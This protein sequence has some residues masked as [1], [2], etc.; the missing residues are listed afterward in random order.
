MSEAQN[1]EIV[2]SAYAAFGRGD[3]AGVINLLAEDIEWVDPGPPAVPFA[4]TH[5]GRA[6]VM[7]MF[8]RLGE[9]VQFTKFEP[10]DFIAQGDR[11]ICLGFF[12]GTVKKTSHMFSSD[13]AMAFTLLAGKII[14]FREYNDTHAIAS[15]FKEYED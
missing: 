1:V 9:T 4:G 12:A 5:H 14:H 15:A 6:E 3:I 8:A 7:Q 10:I 11:V 2:K 13:W